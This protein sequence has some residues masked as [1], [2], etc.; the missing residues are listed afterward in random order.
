[1]NSEKR[2]VKAL[3]SG[4]AILAAPL[5]FII[6]SGLKINTNILDLLPGTGH[7]QETETAI[8]HFSDRLSANHIFFIKSKDWDKA[9]KAAEAFE[10]ALTESELFSEILGRQSD[11]RFNNWFKLYFPHR[12]HLLTPQNRSLIK[13]KGIEK[14]LEDRVKKLYSPQSSLYT[15][16]LENDPLM[17][18]TD[19]IQDLPSNSSLNLKNGFLFK[20]RDGYFYIFINASFK[21]SVFTAGVQKSFKNLLENFHLEFQDAEVLKLGFYPYAER[22]RSQ[23]E[24][25]ISYIGTGSVIGILLLFL[26]I[27][28]SLSQ[29]IITLSTIG[30][31]IV[32]GLAATQLIYGNVHIIT[33]VFGA[34]LT[35]V[36]VDYAFHWLCQCFEEKSSSHIRKGIIWG[37]LT[38][39]I[40]YG[41]LCLTGFPGLTQIAIFSCSGIAICVLL[42]LCLYHDLVNFKEIKKPP[43]LVKTYEILPGNSLKILITIIILVAA[44]GYTKISTSDDIRLLQNRPADLVAKEK[45]AGSLI[46]SFDKSRFILLTAKDLEGIHRKEKELLSK[47]PGDSKYLSL[48]SMV[49][50]VKAQLEDHRLIKNV[51]NHE[52]FKKYCDELGFNDEVAKKTI[53]EVNASD[54]LSLEKFINSPA[55]GEMRNLSWSS[56]EGINSIILLDGPGFEM[57]NLNLQGATYINRVK[58]T[59]NVM[60]TYR[61]KATLFTAGSYIIILILLL[62]QFSPKQAAAM[63]L[64]PALAALCTCGLLSLFGVSL[65]LFNILSFMLILGIGIDYSIFMNLSDKESPA[66]KIAILLSTISTL[67]AFGLLAFSSTPALQT[68]G[69]T[70][71]TGIIL[72]FLFTCRE[73]KMA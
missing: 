28:R 38:S 31:G 47:L 11:S 1:M 7:S 49:P 6:F 46:D 42:V 27:F 44:F 56:S 69:L 22:A 60:K 30:I 37:S 61:W 2:T 68:F 14:F 39:L 45:E 35:G 26:F 4:V 62:I 73:N 13:E 53:E 63:I 64:P 3:L 41:G 57:D 17:L 9:E 59:S 36:C 29:L 20:E 5:L 25:E 54:F 66:T 51:V 52:S 58:D 55:S 65:N 50:A 12:Y 43:I 18:F 21:E 15:S 40:A 71:A 24:W 23:A 34:T 32:W 19:F 48:S 8:K 33:V 16:N 70:L 67:L 72:S 10:K